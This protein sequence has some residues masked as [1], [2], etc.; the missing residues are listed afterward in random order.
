MTHLLGLRLIG[1]LCAGGALAILVAMIIKPTPKL[2]GRVRPYTTSSRSSLGRTPDR[3]T[4]LA[5]GAVT[6]PQGVLQRISRPIVESVLSSLLKVFGGAFDDASMLL[7]LRQADLL[8][9]ISEVNRVH[10]YRVR[11]VSA[12]L[13]WGV[14]AGFVAAVVG[15]P[16]GLV[17]ALAFVG[18]VLG[19]SRRSA[20]VSKTIASRR[21]LMRIE[22]YTINQLL[23]IY[24][25]TSGSP[26]LAAQ[27]LVRRGQGHVIRELSEA[28]RLHTRGMSA[29]RAF[30]RIAEQT[31]EPYAARTYKL[32]ASGSER[33]ADLASALLSLSEDV[34]DFRRQEVRRSATKRQAAMLV[35]IIAFLAPVMLLFIAGPLPSLIFSS[36]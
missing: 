34:R 18:V 4:V 3:L 9:D 22:L 23:A 19:V 16:S 36:R 21:A 5:R 28:L 13:A 33:G 7:K 17:I 11:Q 25:R 8:S 15:L 20:T 12:G 31:P 26:V 24:L 32:L 10:E 27:R 14:G 35:P 6:T 30:D 1:A 29:S 2:A